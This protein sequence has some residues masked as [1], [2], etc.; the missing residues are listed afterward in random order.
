MGKAGAMMASCRV[1]G[2]VLKALGGGRN[3]EDGKI[4]DTY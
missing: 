1:V 3:G 4:L 2:E